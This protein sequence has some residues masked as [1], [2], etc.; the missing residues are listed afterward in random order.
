MPFTLS[1]VSR[2]ASRLPRIC[3]SLVSLSG[4]S[5]GGFSL[6]AAAATP[7]VNAWVVVRPDDTVVVRIARSEMG[8]GTLTGLAQMVAEELGCDW[9]KVTTE[10]PTPGEN[11]ARKRI[12]GNFST[13][14]SRGIRESQDYVR[15]GGAAARMMLVQAAANE[16]GVPAAQCSVNKG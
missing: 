15:K 2:R 16:W 10:Q 11:L 13:G 6:A 7:E 12:W 14:G 5:V 8:Q 3:Q 1:A 4:T 9:A